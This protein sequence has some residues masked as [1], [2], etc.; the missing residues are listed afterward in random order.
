[1]FEHP[2]LKDKILYFKKLSAQQ[3]LD[4]WYAAFEF[5]SELPIETLNLQKK[6]REKQREKK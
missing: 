3:R 4:W 5:I 6:L 2:T 1:M